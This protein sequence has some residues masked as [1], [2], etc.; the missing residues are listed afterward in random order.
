MTGSAIGA[1]FLKGGDWFLAD[2]APVRLVD[3]RAG[4]PAAGPRRPGGA[5]FRARDLGPRR[6]ARRHAIVVPSLVADVARLEEQVEESFEARAAAIGDEQRR[7]WSSRPP[8]AATAGGDVIALTPP[9]DDPR[10]WPE[11]FTTAVTH[12]RSG[13][14]T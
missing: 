12:P 1:L 9:S 8:A 6:V 7:T 3:R 13:C 14:A 2:V 5:L 10:P 4:G 11:R